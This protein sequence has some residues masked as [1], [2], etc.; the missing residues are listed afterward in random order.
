MTPKQ[1]K[2]I[3]NHYNKLISEYGYNE[4]GIGWRKGRLKQRYEIFKKHIIFTNKTILDY[5]CGIGRFYDFAKKN[6]KFKKFYAIEVNNKFK[7]FIKK[8][9]KKNIEIISKNKTPL[10]DIIISNG[11]HN[12]KIKGIKKL[13]FKDLNFFIKKS[14]YAVGLSFINDNVDFKE[15]YLSYINLKQIITFLEKRNLCFVIDQTLNKYETF[16]II[17][18]KIK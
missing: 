8:K 13:L 11:V 4:S 14:K 1:K 10:V 15:K 9:Y 6:F 3:I 5:G 7:K 12:F 2:E 17:F 18:K 16:I